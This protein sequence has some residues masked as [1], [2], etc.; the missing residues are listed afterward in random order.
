MKAKSIL[1]S[2]VLL[3]F[4]IIGGGSIEDL[5]KTFFI[6]LII[7]VILIGLGILWGMN[8]AKKLDE[9][10][11]LADEKKASEYLVMKE[12]FLKEHGKPDK[13]IVV[14]ENDINCEIHVYENEKKVFIMGKEY[15]FRDVL[16]C[17]S[18]TRQKIVRGNVTAVTESNNGSVIGRS[19]VGGIIA[20]PAGAVIGGSTA[21]QQTEFIHEDDQIDNYYTV[22]INM[23]SIKE[24]VITIFTGKD[25]KLTHE[26]V[27][28]M[29]AI[30][31]RK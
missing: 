26:I 11:R 27:A 20:G 4:A 18:S 3:I 25:S 13:T 21:K 29:N 16:S 28:L 17:T 9:K 23:D 19:V 7:G 31:A 30:I 24:P 15:S 14:C 10:K 6:Y 2:I 12:Q 8:E 22:I 5:A 1:S